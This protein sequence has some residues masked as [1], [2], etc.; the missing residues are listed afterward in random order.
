[1]DQP[2]W[3]RGTPV[4]PGGHG[5]GGGR[6]REVSGG[7]WADAVS[8]RLPGGA[9]AAIAAMTD[10]ELDQRAAH[11][12]E[13][14]SS[15]PDTRSIHRPGGPNTDWTPERTAMHERI[16]KRVMDRHRSVPRDRQA[17]MAGGLPGAGKTTTLAGLKL[18]HYLPVNPDEM[19]DE[20]LAEGGWPDLPD[21]VTPMEAAQLFHLE[22]SYLADRLLA[23]ALADGRNVLI[24]ATMG[25]PDAPRSRLRMLQEE[26]YAVRGAFV[27][28]P[29]EV[30][31][32]R[33]AS[34]YREGMRRWAAGEGHGGR[35][36]PDRFIE[37]S[38]GEGR[39]TK[40]LEVFEQL[41]AEGAFSAGW[42][43]YD[44]SGTR[45]RLVRSNVR[46]TT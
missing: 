1:M 23:M 9:A 3:P 18:E 40:N 33:V 17:I 5:P 24:D 29:I 25:S 34:R 38:R 8:A 46:S 31:K 35:P 41:I 4:G 26:G 30:S 10:A 7:D 13:M 16:L 11:V 36:V 19:K 6:F 27:D 39:R 12:V 14:M 21:G 42:E 45:P 2:R 44:N 20:I 28:V 15:L 22:S 32:A 37:A 43:I